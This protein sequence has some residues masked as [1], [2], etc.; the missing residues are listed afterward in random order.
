M[1]SIFQ[2]IIQTVIT[3][4]LLVI[5]LMSTLFIMGIPIINEGVSYAASSSENIPREQ[6]NELDIAVT[7]SVKEKISPTKINPTISSILK[8]GESVTTDEEYKIVKSNDGTI[9]VIDCKSNCY[10][11]FKIKHTGRTIS[12]I[13]YTVVN[14]NSGEYLKETGRITLEPQIVEK[15]SVST[16]SANG[17]KWEKRITE[18]YKGKYWYQLG[19]AKNDYMKIGCK[20]IYRLNLS[21]LSSTKVS[22]CKDYRSQIN[23][24]KSHYNTMKRYATAA[25]LSVQAV[26]ALILLNIAYPASTIITILLGAFSSL[27]AS[28]ASAIVSNFFKS[29]R[30]YLNAKETYEVIKVWGK[31]L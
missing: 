26:V 17:I 27:T 5:I 15:Q 14:N 21:K 23:S 3:R 29:R 30:N 24:C 8:S 13:D 20:A 6:L 11:S 12:A 28:S 9:T 19:Y 16:E 31:K 7:N 2:M 25:G 10:S 22:R 4:K 1:K 18:P